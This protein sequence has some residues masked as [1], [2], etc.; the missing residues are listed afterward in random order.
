MKQKVL[1]TGA[2]GFVGFHLIEAAL[3]KGLDVYAAVRKTS[4]IKHLSSHKIN[5]IHLNFNSVESLQKELKEKEYDFIIHAAGTTKAKNQEEYN[6][7]NATYT[8]NLA[9]AAANAG[10]LKKIVFISSLAALGPSDQTQELITEHKNP[11]PVTAYG[12]SKLLAE[13]QLKKLALP[14]IILRPTAVYGS[15]DKDIFIILRTFSKGFEP[16]IGHIPQQL[17]FVYVKDLA[18]LSVNALFTSDAANGAYNITDGNCYN[19]YEMANIT[20][21]VLN[22]KT[23]KVHLP[24][25]VVKGFALVLEKTYGMLGKTPAINLEKLN[26]L[27][28]INWCCD[29]EKAKTNLH[30]NPSYNLQQ[31]LKETLGWYKQNQWL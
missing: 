19:R 27:T 22:K 18:A 30:Y 10:H 13:E 16:Y 9:N 21:S 17:S 7:V 2:S 29:I 31:G 28:A 5:Y 20:K 1:I 25:P 4:D 24:L 6:T 3:A 14:L 15:R 23:I 12:Q 26:E 8:L 11:H